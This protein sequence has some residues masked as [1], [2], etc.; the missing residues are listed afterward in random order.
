MSELA[1]VL[2]CLAHVAGVEPRDREG[3]ATEERRD[4]PQPDHGVD[5]VV[6]LRFEEGGPPFEIVGPRT[7]ALL[8]C[9]ALRDRGESLHE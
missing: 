6:G 3:S 9:G 7:T 1:R 8:R 2:D 5:V 4:P